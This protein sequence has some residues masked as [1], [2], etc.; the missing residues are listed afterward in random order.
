M[1]VHSALTAEDAADEQ[2]IK[3]LYLE[4]LKPVLFRDW[5]LALCDLSS[6]DPDKDL[7]MADTVFDVRDEQKT[8]EITI[9]RRYDSN[10]GHGSG[11][12]HVAFPDPSVISM[13]PQKQVFQGMYLNDFCK[14]VGVNILAKAL[15]SLGPNVRI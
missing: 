14:S 13:T 7:E 2:K 6:I 4:S 8:A 9:F 3:A 15:T 1:E 5:P 11:V 10:I 12:P